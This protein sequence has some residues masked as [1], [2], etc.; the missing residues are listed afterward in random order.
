MPKLEQLS[1][2]IVKIQLRKKVNMSDNMS[3]YENYKNYK[4]YKL[5]QIEC[6]YCGE[7]IEFEP[8][9]NVC[10]CNLCYA[11]NG[12]CQCFECKI[13]DCKKKGKCLE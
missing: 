2:G 1:N 12:R 3:D 11:I 13:E 6:P 7:T 10:L 4:N 8:I 5:E 9:V